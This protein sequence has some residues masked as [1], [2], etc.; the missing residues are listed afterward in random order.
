MIAGR[1][2]PDLAPA[3]LFA[4]RYPS[5]FSKLIDRLVEASIAYLSAQFTAGVEAV[6]IFESFAAAI[7]KPSC[8][9]GR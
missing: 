8:R 9:S 5:A 7:P 3:R 2:T 4:Y 6:Q 1:G